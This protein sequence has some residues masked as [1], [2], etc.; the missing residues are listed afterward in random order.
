MPW[1]SE[2]PTTPGWYWLRRAAFRSESGAWHEPYPI[3]VELAVQESEE[4]VVYLPGT[5]RACSLNEL[6]VAEWEG[7]LHTPL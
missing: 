3:I 2:T 1:T 6:V 7:P 4:L 5:D